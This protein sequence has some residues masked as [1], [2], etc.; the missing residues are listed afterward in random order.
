MEF[1]TNLIGPKG[2]KYLAQSEVLTNLTSLNLFYNGISN[3]GVK[4]IAVSDNL[5][6]LQN[7]QPTTFPTIRQQVISMRIPAA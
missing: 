1:G 7:R 5:Q 2:A 6:S 3:E 4:F